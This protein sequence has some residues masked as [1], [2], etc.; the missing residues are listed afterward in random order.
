MPTTD[1]ATMRLEIT[2]PLGTVEAATSTDI[3]T[4]DKIISTQLA[5]DYP[6]ADYFNGWYV[7]L[8]GVANDRFVRRVE[9]YAISGN[10]GQ[11]TV[12]GANFTAETTDRSFELYP[13]I[14]HEKLRNAFNRAR[15]DV[16]PNLAIVRD[17]KTLV[18]GQ[19]QYHY[20]LPSTFRGKPKRVWLGKRV[21]ADSIA[22]NLFTDGGF[23]VWTSATALTNWTNAGH[24]SINQEVQTASP[25]NYMVLSGSNSARMVSATGAVRT[26]LETI[27]PTQAIQQVEANVS[28]WVYST[29]AS[30]V[31]ARVAGTDG[32]AHSGGGWELLTSSA[33]TAAGATTVAGGVAITDSTQMVYYADE[34]I[35]I[36]GQSEAVEPR[37]ESALNW[38]WVPPAAGAANGGILEFPYMLPELEVI[39]V[40]GTDML[41]AV[42]TDASTLEIDGELLEPLYNRT[43]QYIAE[44]MAMNG[45]MRTQ[46]YWQE[47]ALMYRAMADA[48]LSYRRVSLPNPRLR[49]PD[50]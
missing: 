29:V 36:L 21:E 10:D 11:L 16:Y 39:R 1:W 33:N 48:G 6:K 15:Q 4:N 37:W 46:G 14:I 45:A 41:S 18:T 2:R 32:T 24:E 13:R 26:L 20:T 9:D 47:K 31:S 22:E 8:L 40:L 43:R 25:K 3:T 42:T 12:T 28:I 35:M 49:V 27:T 30:R 34:A 50:G 5:E 38:R 44:E 17:I 7:L 19:R 23:E